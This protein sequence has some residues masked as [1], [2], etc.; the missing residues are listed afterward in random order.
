MNSLRNQ[1]RIRF[2]DD[3]P[4]PVGQHLRVWQPA[5]QHH[6]QRINVHSKADSHLLNPAIGK[7]INRKPA[8]VISTDGG[9]SL[10]FLSSLSVPLMRLAGCFIEAFPTYVKTQ[11]F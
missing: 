7:E 5:F 2:P 3:T 8:S 4:K 11:C 9:S 6:S 1:P 10:P